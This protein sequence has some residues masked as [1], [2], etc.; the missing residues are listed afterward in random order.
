MP[1]P[2]SLLDALNHFVRADRV[3]LASDFDGVL[4]PFADEP[5]QARPV[6]GALAALQSAVSGGD[7]VA[8]VSGRHLESL[9]RVSGL[10]P[11]GQITLIGSHGA[12]CSR[13]LDLGVAMDAAA[14]RRLA[15]ATA[16][17]ERVVAA[18]PGTRAEHKPSGVVLHTRGLPA[19]VAAA[20]SEQALAVP[21]AIPG[22]HAMRGK[23]VVELSVLE[24]SKGQ[25]VEALS[26]A[27][28]AD[29]VLYLG[30]DVT[31]ETVFCRLADRDRHVM[32]KVGPGETAATHRVDGPA[33]A[34]EVLQRVATGRAPRETNE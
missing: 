2:T 23:D 20:A 18:S 15:A 33:D 1:L 21:D 7:A 4:A 10:R 17:L 12:E 24:V 28:G 3:L 11:D 6:P 22:V 8:V 27:V 5:S 16:A 13:R 29:A 26:C 30:D 31:D 25:A 19:D 14:D 9:Q 32:V 34:V